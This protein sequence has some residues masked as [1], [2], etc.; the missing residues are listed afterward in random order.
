ML[1]FPEGGNQPQYTGIFA[2]ANTTLSSQYYESPDDTAVIRGANVNMSSGYYIHLE[3]RDIK[4]YK[5]SSK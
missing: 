1:T 5:N 3:T 4:Y 2:G